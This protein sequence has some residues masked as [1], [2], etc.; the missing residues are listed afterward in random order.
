MKKVFIALLLLLAIC[1]PISTHAAFQF[2]AGG[3]IS[4]A[5]KL[6]NRDAK[7]TTLDIVRYILSLMGLIAVVM[8]IYGGVR[9]MTS[10]GNAEAIQ[11]ARAIL[12]WAVIGLM[13]IILAQVII[14]VVIGIAPL[15]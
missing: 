5:L 2:D 13:I 10:S 8:F 9:Y 6:T 11:N 12:K 4:N 15:D 7:T 14:T 3:T 1:V